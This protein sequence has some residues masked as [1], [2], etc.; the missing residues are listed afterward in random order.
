MLKTRTSEQA[1]YPPSPVWSIACLSARICQFRNRG[2]PVETAYPDTAQLDKS[3]HQL[4]ADME[5]AECHG[6]LVGML[7]A[8]NNLEP[9]EWLRVLAPEFDAQ[10][11]LQKQA[12]DV[13][14]QLHGSTL[15]GLSNSNME[16]QLIIGEDNDPLE[17]RI[18]MLGDWCQGFLL[19]MARQGWSDYARLPGE[20]SEIV[21]D[22]VEISNAVSYTLEDDA[23]ENEN[24][25]MQLVEYL[26]T[27]VLL[28]N[29]VLNPTQAAP[30]TEQRTLH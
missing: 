30:I 8:K 29:E 12:R 28:V 25:Y 26:R 4:G 24:T 6:L 2:M 16:F 21:Q 5:A 20:A 10:D 15:N 27:G 14:I 11:L 18:E 19:G 23:E 1:L 22:I 17:Q 13:L 7:C 3:L 9:L